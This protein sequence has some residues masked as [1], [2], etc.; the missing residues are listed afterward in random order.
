M[1]REQILSALQPNI[2]DE[3]VMAL[4]GERVRFRELTGAARDA[5]YD[6]VKDRAGNSAFEAT[7]IAATV[8]DEAGE[9][10]FCRDDIEALRAGRKPLLE[11]L[12]QIAMRLN[13]LGNRAQEEATKN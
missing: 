1:Q 12:A 2:V 6:S 9:P 13:G 10:L 4:G 8:V 3:N 11:E 5:L 7:L